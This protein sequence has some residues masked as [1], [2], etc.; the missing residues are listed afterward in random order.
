VIARSRKAFLRFDRRVWLFAM[1]A[2]RFGHGLYFPFSAIYFHN[3]V[4]IPLA[5]AA[6]AAVGLL[7]LALLRRSVADA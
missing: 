6:F 1:L 7:A 3:V 5:V 4:G 2:F